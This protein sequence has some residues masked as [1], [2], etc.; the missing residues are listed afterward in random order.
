MVRNLGEVALVNDVIAMTFPEPLV[1]VGLG[2]PETFLLRSVRGDYNIPAGDCIA[3]KLG[4][5]RHHVLLGAVVVLIVN[6]ED[7]DEPLGKYREAVRKEN[8]L[9]GVQGQ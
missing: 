3:E 8:N 6:G 4:L 2:A 5:L 9:G 7:R 1:E